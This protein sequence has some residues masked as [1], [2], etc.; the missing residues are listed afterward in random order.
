ML[1]TSGQISMTISSCIG[2][3]HSI[4][5]SALANRSRS[6]YFH[7]TALPIGLRAPAADGTRSTR[8]F[9][10]SPAAHANAIDQ[11]APS[12]IRDSQRVRESSG[13]KRS[14]R[15]R[16]VHIHQKAG[17]G[18][19][20]GRIRSAS[21]ESYPC[22]QRSHVICGPLAGEEPSAEDHLVPFGVERTEGKP[23]SHDAVPRN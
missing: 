14:C 1:L 16:R 11:S 7:V 10:A 2:S 19:G 23:E 12:F 21:Q 20:K 15:F 8:S 6:L 18:L 4:P 9:E 5:E 13:F 3:F 17:G 22:L